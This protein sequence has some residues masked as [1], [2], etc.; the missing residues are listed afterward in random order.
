MQWTHENIEVYMKALAKEAKALKCKGWS[1]D[2]VH[3][4]VA[5]AAHVPMVECDD[6]LLDEIAYAMERAGLFEF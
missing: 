5:R 3:E 6:S 1:G 4:F 2:A